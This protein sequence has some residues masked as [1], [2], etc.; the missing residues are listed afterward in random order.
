MSELSISDMLLAFVVIGGPVL[1]ALFYIY[2]MRSTGGRY[3]NPRADVQSDRATEEVYEEEEE[4]LR[5]KQ[6]KA[7][8]SNNPIDR[9]ERKTGTSG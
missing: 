5:A 2:G 6:R 1:L 7:A 3:E 8:T 4:D 9:I